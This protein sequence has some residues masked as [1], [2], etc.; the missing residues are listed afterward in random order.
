MD[1]MYVLECADGSYYTGWTNNLKKRIVSHTEGSASKYTRTRRP[2]RLILE[3]QCESPSQA[4][5]FE[6]RFKRL[7]R[8]QKEKFLNNHDAFI[9]WLTD[10]EKADYPR[11]IPHE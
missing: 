1:V 8:L 6:S 4:R 5:S 7:T 10:K 9:L 2:V 11:V 3:I